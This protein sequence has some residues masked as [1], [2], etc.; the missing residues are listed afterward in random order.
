MSI[1]TIKQKYEKELMQLPN[2]IGLAI[3]E[4]DGK[5]AIIVFVTRKVPKASL[6]PKDML[7]ETL[8][9]FAVD[10]E[11]IGTVSAQS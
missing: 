6:Q 9:G 2:V 11:E 8:G 10:V 3:G 1:E 7:P 5:Q 4:K